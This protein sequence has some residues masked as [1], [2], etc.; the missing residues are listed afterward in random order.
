MRRQ[1]IGVME[2][3]YVLNERKVI[4]H[5][6]FVITLDHLFSRPGRLA[7]RRVQEA[8]QRC[9]K[10]GPVVRA[11]GNRTDSGHAEAKVMDVGVLYAV[12]SP[13]LQKC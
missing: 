5:A 8:D 6:E 10:A 2:Y 7:N 9:R 12:A 1:S 11:S 3:L 4:S 13:E